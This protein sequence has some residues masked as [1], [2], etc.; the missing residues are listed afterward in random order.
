MQLDPV[1]LLHQI[2]E[3]QA[4][5]VALAAPSDM[6]AKPARESLE[7]FL[8][9]LPR[10]WRAG[11]VRPTHRKQAAKARAW[12]TRKDPFKTV[13]PDVLVWL[14]EAPDITAK[15]LFE[16]LQ[17]EH[18]GRYANSQLRTLQRR[19]SEWRHV[20]AKQLV[21]ACLD[22]EEVVEAAAVGGINESR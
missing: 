10:L 14:E 19:V 22:G 6:L 12:R 3:H 7:R 4:A 11:E 15:A 9:E 18:P 21:Y 17:K 5:L 20:M 13:W 8:S 1:G 2:R 16:R